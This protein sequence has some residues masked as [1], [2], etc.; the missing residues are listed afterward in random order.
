MFGGENK[1]HGKEPKLR[2]TLSEKQRKVKEISMPL[3]ALSPH[4]TTSSGEKCSVEELCNWLKKMGLDP[5]GMLSKQFKERKL[6]KQDFK[7]RNDLIETLRTLSYT[8]IGHKSDV[9]RAINEKKTSSSHLHLGTGS[10][11]KKRYSMPVF[12]KFLSIDHNSHPSQ[13]LDEC[14][15]LSRIPRWQIGSVKI[16]SRAEKL[17]PIILHTNF[18]ES[19]M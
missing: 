1:K 6:N 18:N 17:E 19:G 3:E 4:H 5:D 10:Q 9:I 13:T 16:G 11:K 12:A 7:D 15:T 14:Q 8:D 2:N